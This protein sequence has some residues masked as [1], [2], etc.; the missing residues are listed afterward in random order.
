MAT[1][2]LQSFLKPF[3]EALNWGSVGERRKRDD[4]REIEQHQERDEEQKQQ[5]ESEHDNSDESARKPMKRRRVLP[6]AAAAETKQQEPAYSESMRFIRSKTA[7][8]LSAIWGVSD[9]WI[10]NL[11]LVIERTEKFLHAT[12]NTPRSRRARTQTG[13]VM[14]IFDLPTSA[15]DVGRMHNDLLYALCSV[16]TITNWQLDVAARQL[17]VFVF[18]VICHPSR[19]LRRLGTVGQEDAHKAVLDNIETAT[20]RLREQMKNILVTPKQ[21]ARA[22]QHLASVMAWSV[23]QEE[24]GNGCAS[25]EAQHRHDLLVTNTQKGVMCDVLFSGVVCITYEAL[26]QVG[27][28]LQDICILTHWDGLAAYSLCVAPLAQA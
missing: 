25:C 24:M 12:M 2:M 20:H 4:E 11:T 21:V 15:L 14:L 28:S 3:K 27:L 26:K 1:A 6:A 22:S 8:E 17:S 10:P 19:C 18:D 7:K 23:F 9:T 16:L 13:N 5:Q